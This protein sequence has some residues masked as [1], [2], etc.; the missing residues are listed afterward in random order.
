MKNDLLH[1]DYKGLGRY[2]DRHNVYSSM[3][4]FEVYRLLQG[5][6]DQRLKPCLFVRGPERRRCLRK[7]P[8]GICPVVHFSSFCGCMCFKRG[9]LD[10][11]IGF[12]NS[13][14]QT[15]YEYQV[16]LKLLDVRSNLFSPILKK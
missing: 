10:G 16:S 4:A 1:Y 12:R 9:F 3:E 8:T 15:F 13:L 5:R 2:F 14:L 6:K 11:R 7:W